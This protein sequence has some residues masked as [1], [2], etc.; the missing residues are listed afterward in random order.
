MTNEEKTAIQQRLAA[1]CQQKGSQR[2]AANSLDGVSAATISQILSSNWELISDDMWRTVA[3]QTAHNPKTRTANAK[4]STIRRA[5]L[6]ATAPRLSTQQPSRP[7][8]QISVS[9]APYAYARCLIVL[10]FIITITL[11]SYVFDDTLVIAYYYYLLTKYAHAR[12]SARI[13]CAREGRRTDEVRGQ[14][15]RVSTPPRYIHPIRPT[16][17]PTYGENLAAGL[18]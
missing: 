11:S 1:Y 3:A 4:P 7:P 8:W 16:S 15:S 10:L 13:V 12:T 6:A 18:P 2:S 14:S 5:H 9:C 17:T